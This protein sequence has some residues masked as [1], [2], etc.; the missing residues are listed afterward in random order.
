[1]RAL[2]KVIDILQLCLFAGAVF[3][4]IAHLSYLKFIISTRVFKPS[5]FKCMLINYSDSIGRA[6]YENK[7]TFVVCQIILLLGVFSTFVY[8]H[9]ENTDIGSI[10]EKSYYTEQYYVY[11]SER[12]SP[13]KSYRLRASI[14]HNGDDIYLLNTVYWNNGGYFEFDKERVEPGRETQCYSLTDE[15]DYLVTLTYDKV[16]ESKRATALKY[17]DFEEARKR[18]ADE[19]NQKQ[20]EE[21][22]S[23]LKSFDFSEAL[24]RADEIVKQRSN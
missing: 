20:N 5:F 1:M 21:K 22:P 18:R 16:P 23:T 7:K 2:V 17:F 6:M 13:S 24:K 4:V 19:I 11:L 3:V 9:F 10:L 14:T 15:T 8:P 12:S